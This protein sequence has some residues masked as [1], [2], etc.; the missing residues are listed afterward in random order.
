M[1]KQQLAAAIAAAEAEL[2]RLQAIVP[3]PE[4]PLMVLSA[5][6]VAR[7]DRYY[8]FDT[9][10]A[11]SWLIDT[12]IAFDASAYS[13]ASYFHSKEQAE[14]YAR[15]FRTLRLIRHQPG[16]VANNTTKLP[17]VHYIR[18]DGA[19]EIMQIAGCVSTACM[20]P[21]FESREA[22][23]A[24]INAVGE[25]ELVFCANFLAGNITISDYAATQQST[26]QIKQSGGQK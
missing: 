21:C 7:G 14:A 2:A 26:L 15:A 1:N 8:V 5:E 10:G 16:I 18:V 12:S 20:F 13:N 4:A 17:Y 24:A 9:R 11:V 3:E 6:R 22:A 19:V 23:R 25:E